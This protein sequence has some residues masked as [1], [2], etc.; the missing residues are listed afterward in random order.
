MLEDKKIKKNLGNGLEENVSLMQCMH[1]LICVQVVILWVTNT[2]ENNQGPRRPVRAKRNSN[3][4]S[5]SLGCVD[6]V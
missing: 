3:L 5:G 4:F 6:Y 1:M 2:S